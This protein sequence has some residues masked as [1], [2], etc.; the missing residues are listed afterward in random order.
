MI[1]LSYPKIHPITGKTLLNKNI[2]SVAQVPFEFD[3]NGRLKLDIM[4]DALIDHQVRNVGFDRVTID[5]DP[6]YREFYRK[7]VVRDV[8]KIRVHSIKNVFS[9]FDEDGEPEVDDDGNVS[10]PMKMRGS[11]YKFV[12]LYNIFDDNKTKMNKII[13]AIEKS[14]KVVLDA[15]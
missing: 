8:I 15:E 9:Y 14:Y 1:C 6:E 3:A 2:P 4:I 10:I 11:G 7:Q 5:N 13:D 12:V